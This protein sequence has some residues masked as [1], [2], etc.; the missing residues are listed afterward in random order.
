[1]KVIAVKEIKTLRSLIRGLVSATINE[2]TANKDY[3]AIAPYKQTLSIDGHLVTAS[4]SPIFS[5]EGEDVPEHTCGDERRVGLLELSCATDVPFQIN[6]T[7]SDFGKPAPEDVIDSLTD[8]YIDY[9]THAA[10]DN[11]LINSGIAHDITE[12]VNDA[13]FAVLEKQANGLIEVG[14]SESSHHIK[15]KG[16]N[17]DIRFKMEYDDGI[18]MYNLDPMFHIQAIASNYI[19]CYLDAI[20][21]GF[22]MPHLQVN[23]GDKGVFQPE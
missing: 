23:L 22:I 12:A 21:N 13:N 9:L 14:Y 20:V 4:Y 17:G 8:S 15:Y 7:E 16:P 10:C 3:K 5:A 1:M 2:I 11:Y 18:G 19:R 6:F